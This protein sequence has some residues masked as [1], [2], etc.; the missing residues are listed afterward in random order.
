MIS[1]K[2]CASVVFILLLAG[3]AVLGGCGKKEKPPEQPSPISQAPAPTPAPASAGMAASNPAVTI[4]DAEAA[5]KKSDCFTCH[6]VD[7]KLVGP[8][9]SW[10]AFRYKDDKDAVTKL[11]AS[12]KNGSTG[13]WAAYTGGAAMPPHPQL[14]DHDIRAMIQWVMSQQPVEAPPKV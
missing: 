13:M 6:A 9:Y 3:T 5:M 8:A 11:A 10:I 4:A 1:N 2:R 12:V 14:P 7:K